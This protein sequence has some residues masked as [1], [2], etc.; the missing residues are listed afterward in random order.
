VR[1]SQ[2]KWRAQHPDYWRQY[3]KRRPEAASRNREQ[4]RRRDRQR[5]LENL[6]KNNLAVDLKSMACEVWFVGPT[7]VDLAKNNLA[8]TK[9]FI[10]Q[11]LDGQT[12][13]AAG[14][15]KNNPIEV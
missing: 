9:V 2:S 15:A 13:L 6:A 12:G 5:R 7:V 10:C 14:L 4:Q 8:S 1:N 11:T 3:R